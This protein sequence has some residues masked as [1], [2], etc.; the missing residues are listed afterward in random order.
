[1]TEK[2][3][4]PQVAPRQGG[5]FQFGGNLPLSKKFYSSQGIMVGLILLVGG[6][7]AFTVT[8]AL[9]E[10]TQYQ[11][12]AVATNNAAEIQKHVLQTNVGVKEFILTGTPAAAEQA[13]AD[14]AKAG[15]RAEDAI[16]SA[17]NASEREQFQVILDDLV[18]YRAAFEEAVAVQAEKNR[19]VEEKLESLGVTLREQVGRIMSEAEAA[20][21]V[22]AAYRA[23]V[24]QQHLTLGRLYAQKYLL[25]ADEGSFLS[26]F[27]ALQQADEAWI[28]LEGALGE[29]AL[30]TVVGDGRRA[31]AG[32]QD[33]LIEVS[34][35]VSQINELTENRIYAVGRHIAEAIGEVSAT[36][37]ATQ[38]TMGP[39]LQREL[40][41]ARDVSLAVAAAAIVAGI[42]IALWLVR[43]VARPIIGLTGV[44]QAL[45]E[46]RLDVE[47]AGQ[48]RKDEVGAMARTVAVF[49]DN[50]LRVKRLQ[51]EQREAETRAQA[52]KRA[53][54]EAL[55]EQ[56]ESSVGALVTRLSQSVDTVRTEAVTMTDLLENASNMS[57]EVASSS[58]QSNSGVQSVSAAAEELSVTTQEITQQVTQAA[59]MARSATSEAHRGNQRI[60]DLSQSIERIGEVVT[61]IQ[62]IAEQTN[63]LALN[64]T[65][66][67][68]RAGEAGKGFAVVAS[69]VKSLANQ[70]AKATEDIRKQIETVQ[71]AGT[72]AVSAI[73]RIGQTIEQLDTLNSGVASAVEEQSATTR[74]IAS[75]IQ[76][77]AAGSHQVS[78]G[79]GEVAHSA[80][81]TLSGASSVLKQCEGL[82]EGSRS[83][84]SEV[85]T[86]LS[87]VRAA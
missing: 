30:R 76:E 17:D 28:A 65:I 32:F 49:R 34:G 1:M 24:V 62:D 22:E 61:L 4:N 15:Q 57:S 11:D 81:R 51:E 69:E 41:N 80:Q 5:R 38:A 77:V 74:E 6:F 71:L 10:F 40:N 2:T 63:L 58:E 9:D 83:L 56:F 19:V 43:L 78:S 8:R 26:A 64:A 50:A 31:A 12:A 33:A 54:M 36:A 20:G 82:A 47:A 85:R 27:T 3:E 73:Q 48:E 55:A 42:A 45:T 44:M 52:E 66:E 60:Q 68:A 29:S 18:L 87:Q 37:M 7:G 13:R 23:G 79:I 67:A 72:E 86:F 16:E 59:D 75:S 46:D 25:H 39:M 70:S 21:N 84:E 35:L 14:L 53:A